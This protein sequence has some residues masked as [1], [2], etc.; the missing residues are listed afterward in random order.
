LRYSL[1]DPQRSVVAQ[2]GNGT[3]LIDAPREQLPNRE[4]A[5]PIITGSEGRSAEALL[6][7][8]GYVL[9]SAVCYYL[10]TQIAWALRFPDSKVSLFFPPQAVLLCILLLVPTRHWWAY[11]LASVSVHFLATQQAG[12]PTMYALTCEAFDALKCVSAAAGI[13]F[14]IKSPIKAITLR[15]AIY[16]VLIAVA[17]VPFGTAFWGAAFTVSYGFGTRYWIE[18]RNLGISNAVT[19]V[20]LVPSILLGANLLFVKRTRAFLPRRILEAAFVGSCTAALG[21]FVFDSTTAGPGTSPALLYAPI[22][23]LIWAALRF[24]LGGI[25][26]SMLI[27]TIEAIWGTMRGH[28][29]FL[30]QTP[31]ENALA[32]QLFLLVTATPL[33]LLAVVIEDER[34]SKEALRE[35]ASL[36]G[37]AAEAGNLAMWVLDVS[38]NDVWMTERGRSLFGF[39]PDERLD[40]SASFARVHPE[41]RTAREDAIQQ[42]IQTRGQ[43]DMEYRVQKLD[44]TIRWIHGRGRCLG[45]DGGT[46]PKLFGVSMDVTARKEA[47]ASAAQKRA[48]LEHISRIATLGQLTATLTHELQQP[49]AAIL[50]NS[51]AGAR[52]LDASS[53]DLKKLR[54]TLTGIRE[55]T[56]RAGEVIGGLRA[57]FKRDSMSPGLTNV[58]I[59]NVIRFVERIVYGDANLRRVTVDLDLSPDVRPIKGESVQLQQVILNLMLNAFSAMS[60]T[61][62]GE[63]HLV[64]RTRAM[65]P[66]NLLIEV[67]D[68][69]TGIAEEKLEAIFSPFVTSKPEGL[70]MGL[71]ICRSI[72]ERHGGSISAA[73]NPD[74]GA[75]FSITLPVSGE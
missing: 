48:E 33:M 40:F 70:G 14:L 63:A 71:S 22:P 36:M 39:S 30:A 61:E 56:E 47:E 55:V 31:I 7:T 67:E 69:G 32:L 35:S 53:P 20:V 27:I 12:W 49:L 45:P 75:K 34:R 18:W 41:D 60:E 68:S 65:D 5:D 42:A 10:S 28:G 3:E 29:P 44:G 26:V 25:S 9:A 6:R 72:I 38:G 24:G 73:N 8:V 51:H 17:I 2:G 11:V 43:Y 54:I 21:I 64:V 19:A 52:L 58:D 57:M 62:S 23:L 74:G 66:S 16:F 59:N 46:G 50:I 4:L 1:G 37:V 13:R 15:D